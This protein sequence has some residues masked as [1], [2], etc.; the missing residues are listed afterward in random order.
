M[1]VPM[2]QTTAAG[3]VDIV[4]DARRSLWLYTRDLDPGLFDAPSVID[5]L[6]RYGT[7]SGRITW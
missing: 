2:T 1:F 4:N 6:R 7:D 5:A 3:I